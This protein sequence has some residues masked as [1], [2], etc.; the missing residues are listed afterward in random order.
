MAESIHNWLEEESEDILR[1]S[2]EIFEYAELADR[3]VKSSGRL[4]EF[5]KNQGFS[6]VFGQG[7]LSTAFRAEWGRGEPV[8]GFLAEYDAL[9][10]LDQKPLPRYS[11]DPSRAGHGCGHNLLGTGA[12]AGAAALKAALEKEN[13]ECTVVLYGCP[14]EE[15]LHGKIAMAHGG[16]FRELDA[17]LTWH[18]RDK[19]CAG[20][21]SHQAMDSVQFHFK[22]KTAHAASTPHLGRSALDACELMNVGVNYL[23]EHVPVDVRMHY[24]YL[25]A[26]EKPNIVPEYAAVW[27]FIRG[28][29]RATVDMTTERVVDIARGAALMT[30]TEV[31]HEFLSRGYET[32]INHS[33]CALVHKTMTETPLP[34]YTEKEKAFAK[35]LAENTGNTGDGGYFKETVEPLLGRVEQAMGST[36]VSDVSQ[37]VPTVSFNAVCAPVGTP[38]HHWG[39]AANA[40]YTTGEKGMM[41][42]AE[43]LARAG[44]A[45]IEDPE[46]L[47]AA[48]D[49]FS[50]TAKGWWSA[51]KK[52]RPLK[53]LIGTAGREILPGTRRR[54]RRA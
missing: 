10:G 43:V 9:P 49:E 2:R 16:S 48:K 12:A 52:G 4:A 28:K 54:T 35:E 33:L 53:E 11:G 20:E 26:G 21:E 50:R 18:P 40:G 36:D 6:V 17:A 7:G 15:I 1:L 31:R 8:I 3:E 47:A 23:R 51:R 38:L 34:V 39:F 45:L 27:Y 46:I 37:I 14:S 5:M 44:L 19:N 30:G 42:A 25:S 29:D 24:S 32:L 22:G 41:F 13:K